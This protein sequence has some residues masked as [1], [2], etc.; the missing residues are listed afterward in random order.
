[1]EIA[2][3]LRKLVE[4]PL[5]RGLEIDS[6]DCSERRKQ[7]IQENSFLKQIYDDWYGGHRDAIQNCDAKDGR[8]LEI[9]SGGGFFKEFMEGED[10]VTSDI[11]PLEGVDMVLDARHLETEFAPGSLRGI[12]M[13]NV[14]HHIPDVRDFFKSSETALAQ[15]GV[16]TMVEPWVSGWAK[17]IYNNL[18]HELFDPKRADWDFE[19]T[20]PLSGSN[21]ALPWIIF[22]RDRELFEK[23][24]PG[25]KVE[26]VQPMMPFRYLVSGGVSMI[27]LQ[28]KAVYGLW[29][30]LEGAL[31]P[32]KNQLAMFAHI[33]VS[34]K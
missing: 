16:L 19:T 12:T 23:S 26:R 5:T 30:G 33:V 34:K 22:Q 21:G 28:P 32:F 1:M 24:F 25:L 13:V 7:I 3:S 31:S 6:P 9:G 15:G 14:L 17:L 11:I 29:K 10:V 27:Q 4:H 18:H 2:N 8:I 20:G